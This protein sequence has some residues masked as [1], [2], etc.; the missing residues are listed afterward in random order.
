MKALAI[1]AFVSLFSA[2][3]LANNGCSSIKDIAGLDSVEKQAMVVACEQKK[4]ENVGAPVPVAPAKVSD[5][6]NKETMSEIS[7][8]AKVAGQTVKEVAAELNVAA[9]EFVKTPVGMLTAGLAIWY[10]AGDTIEGVFEGVWNTLGGV[11]LMVVS[12]F[13][14][15]KFLC[16]ALL[17]NVETKTVK[18][19]FGSEKEVKVPS[20]RSWQSVRFESGDELVVIL[21]VCWTASMIVGFL[22]IF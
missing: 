2:N 13:F 15:R 18:G 5:V 6:I 16:F 14:Y 17:D 11:V 20:Y 8:I 12:T 9:N 19:W 1:V 21:G 4:L 7:E 3:A 22:I 10:V